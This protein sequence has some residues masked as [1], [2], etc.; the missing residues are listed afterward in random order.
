M[1]LF[2]K[3]EVGNLGEITAAKF[4]KKNKYKILHKNYKTKFG[5]IDI[6]CENSE[7]IVF[8]EVKTRKQGAVIP[9]YTAVNYKKQQHIIRTAGVYLQEN[10]SEKQPRFDIIEVEHRVN[11][12]AC[13]KEHYEDAFWQRG[14][15]GVF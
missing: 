13:V 10:K 1:A 11:G 9:G 8:V 6:I 12:T 4:L 15:Y 14:D 5:E 7:Y 2:S 3:K